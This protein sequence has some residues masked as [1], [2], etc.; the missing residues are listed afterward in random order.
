LRKLAP[1]SIPGS[2]VAVGIVADLGL[3]VEH[4]VTV[5]IMIGLLAKKAQKARPALNNRGA[6]TAAAVSTNAP[7]DTFVNVT[8]M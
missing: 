3:L 7:L 6:S 4:V 1:H 5:K 8:S 2:V